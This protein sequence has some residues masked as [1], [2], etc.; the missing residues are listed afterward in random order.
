MDDFFKTKDTIGPGQGMGSFTAVHLAWLVAIATVAFLVMRYC[1]KADRK[2]RRRV[3]VTLA[4]LTALDELAKYLIT[5]PTGQWNW[6]YLPL[7]LCSISVFAVCLHAITESDEVGEFLYALSLP[8]AIMAL[9]FPNWTNLLPAWNAMCIHSFTIHG[10]LVVYPLALLACGWRPSFKRLAYSIIPIIVML[11]VAL[12]VNTTL[13]T[14]FF[15]LSSG[16]N[17]NPLSFI[18]GYI[19]Q[20]YLLC[21]PLI[22]AIIWALMYL[23]PRRLSGQQ[24]AFLR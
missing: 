15:F 24:R 5:I 10:L 9:V 14:N 13:G 2:G 18:E 17:G 20:W 12:V 19:G 21:W 23:L 4:C 8:S 11:I 3:M 1:R 22:F 6:E 7:H 16:D